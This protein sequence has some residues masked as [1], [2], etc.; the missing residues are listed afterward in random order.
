MLTKCL[1]KD[2]AGAFAKASDV[3]V[4]DGGTLFESIERVAREHRLANTTGSVDQGIM[5]G[6]PA[7]PWLKRT[8]ERLFESQ[9]EFAA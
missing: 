4:G 8:R 6:K 9:A 7:N 5:W 2:R 1:A 3:S